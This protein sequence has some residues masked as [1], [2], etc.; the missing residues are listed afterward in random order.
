[1]DKPELENWAPC[2]S[3]A[4]VQ[5]IESESVTPICSQGACCTS[6]QAGCELVASPGVPAQR[7]TSEGLSELPS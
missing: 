4:R 2:A 1:M 5:F 7:A 6:R 3:C